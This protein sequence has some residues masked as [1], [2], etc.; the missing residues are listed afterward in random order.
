MLKEFKEFA[1]KG[2]V[3]DMAIGIIIGAAFGKIITSFVGDVLMPPIG[4]LLGNVDFS[5]LFVVL[6]E[7]ARPGPYATLADAASAGGQG[8]CHLIADFPNADRRVVAGGNQDFAL[9]AKSCDAA[10]VAAQSPQ[11]LPVRQA[12][13]R[14]TVV[15][16]HRSRGLPIRR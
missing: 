15:R 10:G 4:L 6:R 16:I 2:N 1:M 11:Q 13:Q 5:N 8:F 14:Y 12:P 7:G 9:A 3:L